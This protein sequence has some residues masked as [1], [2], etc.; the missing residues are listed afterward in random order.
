MSVPAYQKIKEVEDAIVNKLIAAAI[1]GINGIVFN[2]ELR[3][4]TI[5]PPY[6]HV[7]MDPSPIDDL[8]ALTDYWHFRYTV[9]VVAP[10]YSTEDADQARQLALQASSALLADRQLGHVVNDTVRLAWQADYIR[11]LPTEQL[12]GA[13]MEMESRFQ[14]REVFP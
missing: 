7:F 2:R 3:D 14:Y 12:F 11:E 10:S 9:M 1:T 6:I 8:T 13:A 5:Q 4:G